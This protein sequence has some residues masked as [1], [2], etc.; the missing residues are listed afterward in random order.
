MW[1]GQTCHAKLIFGVTC[2]IHSGLD[3]HLKQSQ[4]KQQEDAIVEQFFCDPLNQPDEQINL[5]ER[6][7]V[8]D[9]E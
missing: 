3:M 8:Q 6:L 7:F 9:N 2:V 5:A 4:A 1:T